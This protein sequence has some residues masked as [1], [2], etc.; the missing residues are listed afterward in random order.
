MDKTTCIALINLTPYD[1]CVERACA[2]SASNGGPRQ[3][4]FEDSMSRKGRVFS[5]LICQAKGLIDVCAAAHGT[6][7]V[8][9][10][11]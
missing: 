10:L 11:T 4:V 7:A 3:G 2:S 6:K 1:A 5:R 9:G 8:G